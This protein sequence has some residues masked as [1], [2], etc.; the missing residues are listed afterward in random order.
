M[1]KKVLFDHDGGVDDLLSLLLLL[2]MPTVDLLGVTVTP[3]DCYLEPGL[4]ATHQI[5]TKAGQT[6]IPI[7]AGAY[8]GRNAFP[9]DWRAQPM[10]INALPSLIEIAL[11][12][13]TRFPSAVELMIEQLEEATT[14][15][16]ILL[17]GPC[18]NLVL[19]L[20][21]APELASKIEQVIWMGGAVGVGGN[22]QAHWHDGSAEWNAYWAPQHTKALLQSGL[23]LV[24]IPLDVTNQVP[25]SLDF[26]KQVAG[27]P[28][29]Y[30]QLAGQLWAS[31]VHTIPSYHYT[32]YMW[33]VLATCYICLAD[34][35]TVEEKRLLVVD[36]GPNAGQ[37]YESKTGAFIQVATGVQQTVFYQQVLDLL[38]ANF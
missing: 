4:Q 16:T 26:L 37:I 18:S 1:K 22:V 35:F 2:K 31:T 6:S 29:D 34:A 8:Y 32:Y 19:A 12:D 30:A 11:P 21:Q 20:E 14:S 27:L 3:A 23:P 33:D 10:F 28:Y 5:L 36:Q 24:L 9:A 13:V 38:S 7:G 15:V 17:T 25:V